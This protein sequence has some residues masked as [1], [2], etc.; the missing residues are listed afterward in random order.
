[1]Y[2]GRFSGENISQIEAQVSKTLMYE[3]YTFPNPDFLDDV[4]LVIGVD[5]NMAPV[6]GNGQINYALIIILIL[7]M[8]CLLTHIYMVQDPITSDMSI[9]SNSIISNV[10]E[11]VGFVNGTAH[12]GSSGWSDPS[13]SNADIPFL[14]NDNQFEL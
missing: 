14:N 5:A 3:K 11:G 7:L 8:D 10:S 4:L 12:C 1:M 6:H 13:F 9:A 2:Y